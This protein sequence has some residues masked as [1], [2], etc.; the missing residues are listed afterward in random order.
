MHATDK[1]S[2]MKSDPY[3]EFIAVDVYGNSVRRQTS[4]RGGDQNP[5]WNQ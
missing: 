1:V 2:L 3:I 5:D 4:I